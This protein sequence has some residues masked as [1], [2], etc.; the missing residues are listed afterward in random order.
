MV[1]C[2]LDGLDFTP[3][4]LLCF[5]G[6]RMFVACVTKRT[7]SQSNLRVDG[8]SGSIQQLFERAVVYI[9]PH[10]C[11]FS[12]GKSPNSLFLKWI[13]TLSH[14]A[15]ASMW[16]GPCHGI[17]TPGPQ[18]A[19]GT[20]DFEERVWAGETPWVR[21]RRHWSNRHGAVVQACSGPHCFVL[22]GASR[23]VSGL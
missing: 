9:E 21:S 11:H 10:N 23:L 5:C 18:P 8:A 6:L 7:K 14:L 15:W 12:M 1:V 3:C 19:K 16:V 20:L 2:Y 22:G 17:H 4:Q 13:T